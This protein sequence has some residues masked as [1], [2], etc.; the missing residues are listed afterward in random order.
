MGIPDRPDPTASIS[1]QS[2]RVFEKVT[3]GGHVN[4]IAVRDILAAPWL[5]DEQ[6]TCTLGNVTATRKSSFNRRLS[7]ISFDGKE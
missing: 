2:T 3:S 1:V 7:L 6:V 4:A 5:V